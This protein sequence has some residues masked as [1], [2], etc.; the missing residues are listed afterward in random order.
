MASKLLFAE[1]P[2]RVSLCSTSLCQALGQKLQKQLTNLKDVKTW[3]PW[4]LQ[5]KFAMRRQCGLAAEIRHM[6]WELLAKREVG[7]KLTPIGN[8]VTSN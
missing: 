1:L 4:A 6:L 5:L 2:S 3:A 7:Q 8:V